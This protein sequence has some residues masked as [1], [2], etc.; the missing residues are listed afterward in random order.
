MNLYSL[1][2]YI[3]HNGDNHLKIINASRGLIHEY[4]NLKRKLFNCS[5]NIYFNRQCYQKRLV[6]NY[7]KI[8]IPINSPA[9]KFT[10]RKTQNLRIKD[11]IKYLYMKKQQLNHKLYYLHLSL[12]NTWGNTWQYVQ[13]TIE[14]MT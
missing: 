4:E 14:E 11:E 10:Q 12:A 1:L 3:E 2:V 9:V 13:Y 8:K 6:P 7:A 5:A